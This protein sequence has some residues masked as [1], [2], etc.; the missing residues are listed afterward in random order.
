MFTMADA[1][2][3]RLTHLPKAGRQLACFALL[4]AGFISQSY[5]LAPFSANYQ[6][7]YNHKI[8]APAVRKLTQQ[9]DQWVYEFTAKVP[10]LASASEKS[11]FKVVNDQIVS[12]SFYQQYK[13]PLVSQ[14]NSF[15]FN[16]SA[17]TITTTKGSK[18]RQLAWQANTL[19]DLNV[20]L[21]IREDLKRGGVKP[22]YLIAGYKAV[23]PRKFVVAGKARITTPAGTFDTIKVQ[24]DPDR[25]D[26]TSTFWLAPSMDY[27][28]VQMTHNENNIDYSL[29]L[30]SYQGP[31]NAAISI[32]TKA[33]AAKTEPAKTEAVKT[34]TAK[35]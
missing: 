27:L 25:T 29:V 2:M 20:E 18:V 12:Q 34:A 15:I 33:D 16:N 35:K 5:A 6:F 30:N 21:Q 9:G 11:T 19:D 13:L 17:K 10:V 26:M 4:S 31:T 24:L 14:T 23:W 22:S 3:I 1:F 7:T 32:T 28:P 8:S